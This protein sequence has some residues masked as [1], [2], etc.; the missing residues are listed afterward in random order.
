MAATNEAILERLKKL[1]LLDP[2]NEKI[3]DI[4]NSL[5]E[6]NKEIKENKQNISALKTQVMEY[7]KENDTLLSKIQFFEQHSKRKNIIIY[8]IEEKETGWRELRLLL[9]G[10]FRELLKIEIDMNLIEGIYRIGK[11]YGTSPRPLR[12]VFADMNTKNEVIS[13]TRNLRGTKI[14]ISQDYT[15]PEREKRRT[16]L[17]YRRKLM[18]SGIP[19][20]IKG[21]SLL[22]NGKLSTLAELEEQYGNIESKKRNRET[23]PKKEE[24][25]KREDGSSTAA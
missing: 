21:F 5:G 20:K 13:S 16:L 6:M 15:E 18:D 4:S 25:K 11:R 22:V 17:S 9:D 12:V 23:P 2:M 14:S 10:F 3:N 1:D 24:K 7:K 19:V 8:N